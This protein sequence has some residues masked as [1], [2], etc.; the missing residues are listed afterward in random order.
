MATKMDLLADVMKFN[1]WK[2]GTF[3]GTIYPRDGKPVINVFQVNGIGG[4]H[5]S[6]EESL[7]LARWL[8]SLHEEA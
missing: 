4:I 1:D 7:D 6:V 8:L 2:S 3:R 5:L